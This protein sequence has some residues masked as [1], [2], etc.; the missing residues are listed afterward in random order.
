[1]VFADPKI[2]SYAAFGQ[3]TFSV[4][5]TFRLIGGLRYTH[6]RNRLSGELYTNQPG[7]PVPP[8]ALPLLLLEFGGEKSFD[9]LNWR[10]GGEFDLTPDNMLFFTASTG[11][12]AGGFNQTVAP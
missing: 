2:R 4:S 3:A 7:F 9:A 12:K 8:E 6:E 1:I 11:F 10:A 5:D